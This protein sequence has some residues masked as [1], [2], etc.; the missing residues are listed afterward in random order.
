MLTLEV[1][2]REF[3]TMLA[4]LR[5][6][7]EHGQ[8]D[9]RNRSAWIDDIATNGGTVTALDEHALDELCLRLN[10]PAEG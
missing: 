9:P 3:H 7:R 4:A 6:Y 8:A 5:F 10:A 1:S 2:D